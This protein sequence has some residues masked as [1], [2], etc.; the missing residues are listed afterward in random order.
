MGARKGTT[1]QSAFQFLKGAISIFVF[2]PPTP[3]SSGTYPKYL[4]AVMLIIWR[5][6]EPGLNREEGK[7]ISK[8]PCSTQR[9]NLTW[10]QIFRL[11]FITIK[12][13]AHRDVDV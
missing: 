10:T 3:K 7:A 13:E 9:C 2:H 12:R 5:N 11:V 8:I 4:Y 6:V 1:I